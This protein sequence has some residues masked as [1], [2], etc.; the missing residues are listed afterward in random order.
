[1]LFII[2]KECERFESV[3]QITVQ[4]STQSRIVTMWYLPYI[5]IF[6]SQTFYIV[7][8][9][10]KIR[11]FMLMPC[12]TAPFPNV[13]LFSVLNAT[14]NHRKHMF[15]AV[16]CS[17]KQLYFQIS[18]KH[19]LAV[20]QVALATRGMATDCHCLYILYLKVYSVTLSSSVVT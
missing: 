2:H 14:Q 11:Q 8:C 20:L 15:Q 19:F 16:P 18:G 5:K 10:A 3:V 13:L 12:L 9:R 6:N 4:R 7:I 17:F 1:M